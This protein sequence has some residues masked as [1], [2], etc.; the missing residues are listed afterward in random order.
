MKF[1]KQTVLK[2]EAST[3]SLISHTSPVMKPDISFHI[4]KSLCKQS[5]KKNKG[6]I[7]F[8]VYFGLVATF[9]TVK[10]YHRY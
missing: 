3:V 5:T 1:K 2:S 4:F 6:Q 8:N 7:C 9:C 10:L